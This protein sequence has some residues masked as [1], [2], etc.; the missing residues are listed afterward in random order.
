MMKKLTAVLMFALFA[1]LPVLADDAVRLIA[2]DD[3]LENSSVLA[4]YE[5]VSSG[6]P[7]AEVLRLLGEAGFTTIIDLRTESEDRGFEEQAAV[8]S[9]GMSYISLPIAGADGITFE[10]AEE[11]DRLIESGEGRVFVHCASGNR[12]GALIALGA[13]MQ[14]ASREDAIAAGKSAGMTR[15]EPLVTEKLTEK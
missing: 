15:L 5:I 2:T 10:N 1:A 13:S 3:I 8:E 14:G 7:D 6:Q 9:L 12:V 4:D 11:L